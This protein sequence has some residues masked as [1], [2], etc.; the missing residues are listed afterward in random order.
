MTDFIRNDNYM[1]AEEII[2]ALS[3]NSGIDVMS[4]P[5]GDKR[6]FLKSLD[7]PYEDENIVFLPIKTFYGDWFICEGE[8]TGHI[9]EAYIETKKKIRES[10]VP[11]RTIVGVLIDK[12]E[13]HD[14]GWSFVINEII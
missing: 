4:L 3:I 10:E 1:N 13:L 9:L 8:R 14:G 12:G 7:R 6:V 2:N 5:S 11:D